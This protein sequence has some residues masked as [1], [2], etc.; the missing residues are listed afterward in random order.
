MQGLAALMNGG[1]GGGTAVVEERYLIHTAEGHHSKPAHSI[2][3]S[4]AL[5]RDFIVTGSVDRKVRFLDSTNGDEVAV[6][7]GHKRSVMVS[8]QVCVRLYLL[9]FSCNCVCVYTVTT[10]C[11]H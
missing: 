11:G 7:L 2:A 10:G 8:Y 4:H 9:I 6:C 3:L 5:D 1:A